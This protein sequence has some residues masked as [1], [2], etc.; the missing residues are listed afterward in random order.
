LQA[1]Q[2]LQSFRPPRFFASPENTNKE[3]TKGQQFNKSES[4]DADRA[5]SLRNFQRI[6]SGFSSSVA[7]CAAR[8]KVQ[9]YQRIQVAQLV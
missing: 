4:G 9:K 6:Q 8:L 5:A 7:L 1:D 2:V 3:Q